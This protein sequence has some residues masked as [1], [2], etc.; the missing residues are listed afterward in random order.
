VGLA[1]LVLVTVTL[2]TRPT[3]LVPE[4]R[5]V[6]LNM[7]L[8][9]SCLAVSFPVV[10]GQLIGRRREP[11]PIT[12]C[13]L[14][15]WLA[16]FLSHLLRGDPAKAIERTQLFTHVAL[17][18]L[19]L[20]GLLDTPGRFRFFLVGLQLALAI[21]TIISL[22]QY[23]DY[24]DVST[25][26]D[27]KTLK[28]KVRQNDTEIEVKRLRGPGRLLGDPNDVCSLF[29]LGILLGLYQVSDRRLGP[30]RLLALVPV[31]LC[32]FG[33][34]LTRSRGGMLGLLAGLAVFSFARFGWRRTMIYL[35]PVLLAGLA[36]LS[37]RGLSTS[38]G[39][40]QQRIQMWAEGLGLFRQS[41]LFGVGENRFVE[42]LGG[43]D[44]STL[45]AHNSYVHAFAELGFFG[46]TAFVGAFYL[47]FLL[48]IRARPALEAY[49]DAE[50]RRMQPY[51]LGALGGY[52]GCIF[53]LSLPYFPATYLILGLVTAYL[54]VTAQRVRLGQ[55]AFDE[56]LLPR[57]VI[58]GMATVIALYVFVRVFA[59]F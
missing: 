51:L 9:L 23:Y 57:L 32:L 45:V 8:T 3:E 42:A 55:P 48:L 28:E 27:L 11:S 15:V 46:G 38:E 47:G 52:A 5:S 26:I 14:C 7:I 56:R 16:I 2:L 37:L 43:D 22:L 39:T 20:V 59:R 44:D 18:Y 19:L 53:S 25:D 30:A 34:Y 31:G 58:V 29:V 21:M 13:V 41:P 40:S 54:N 12:G 24:I 36:A 33:L 50:F 4:L 10:L 49:P 17:Y 6:N 35:W 1:L